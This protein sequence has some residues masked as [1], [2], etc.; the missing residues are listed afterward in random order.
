MRIYDDMLKDETMSRRGCHLF[1]ENER[2]V[3]NP[4]TGTDPSEDRKEE[5]YRSLALARYT[6]NRS[7]RSQS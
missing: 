1:H 7:N 3:P 6:A 2:Q 4:F 5:E